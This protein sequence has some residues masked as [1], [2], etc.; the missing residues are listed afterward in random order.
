MHIF[1]TTRLRKHLKAGLTAAKLD[2]SRGFAQHL[3]TEFQSANQGF[4]DAKWLRRQYADYLDA[5][6]ARFRA[7]SEAEVEKK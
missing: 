6:A 4:G 7:E 3:E 5:E 1:D 2:L